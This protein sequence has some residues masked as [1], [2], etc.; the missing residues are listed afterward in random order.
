ML[1]RRSVFTAVLAIG[2]IVVPWYG[3]AQSAD[4]SI[5]RVPTTI[6]RTGTKDVTAELV[7]YIKSVPDG[8]TITFPANSRYRIENILLVGFRHNLVIDGSG[9]LFFATTTGSGVPPTGPN[10]VQQHWPRHRAQWLVHNS[11]NITLR[12][13]V[14]RGANPKAGTSD[15]AYVVALE[16]QHGV[17]FYDTIGGKL[18]DCTITDTYGDF[19]YIGNRAQGTTVRGCTMARSGRQGVTVSYARDVLIRDNHISQVRR[20]AIDLE[21][22]TASWGVY[23]VWIA[24]NTFSAIRLDTVG[25]KAE[26]DVS[27][28]VIAFNKMVGEPM[29]IRNTPVLTSGPRRHHWYVIGN[30]SDTTYG[31]PHGCYWITFTDHIVIRD[32]YQPL[33]PGRFQIPIQTTGSTDVV[34][35]RNVFLNYQ[36]GPKPPAAA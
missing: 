5:H 26:G 2:A 14:V 33:Q 23:N 36:D 6:D 34:K 20:T 18:E 16:A 31:S 24:Y 11:T 32:N 7:A 4:A 8:S 13:V 27:K 21:P 22:Y 12:N 10:A 15:P 17:E 9:S 3:L 30:T 19:V 28:I 35:L 25:A 29:S 1:T